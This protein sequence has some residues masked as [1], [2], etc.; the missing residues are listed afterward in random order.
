MRAKIKKG[1]MTFLAAAIL[2]GSF[3]SLAGMA[4][5]EPEVYRLDDAYQWQGDA[6]SM[7]VV[8]NTM[9]LTTG[10]SN[11]SYAIYTGKELEDTLVQFEGRFSI[12]SQWIAVRFRANEPSQNTWDNSQIYALLI[13]ENGVSVYRKQ[14]GVETTLTSKACSLDDGEFH[15]VKAGVYNSGNTAK[16]YFEVDGNILI[17]FADPSPN[18]LQSGFLSFNLYGQGNSL[19]VKTYGDVSETMQTTRKPTD[20]TWSGLINQE[21]W[22]SNQ[23]T[24]LV[25]DQ[26][27]YA[28]LNNKNGVVTLTGEGTATYR[29]K[30]R[31]TAFSFK[32]SVD[33]RDGVSEGFSDILFLKGTRASFYGKNSYSLRLTP[34]GR[35]SLIRYTND[36]AQTFP[37]VETGLDFTQPHEFMV[38]IIKTGDLS[39]EIYVYVD[40]GQ[41]GSYV[42]RDSKYSPNL[43]DYGF[44]GIHN[45]SNGVISTL[46]DVKIQGYEIRYNAGEAVAPLLYPDYLVEE[47]GDKII[48]WEYREDYVEYKGVQ[49]TD[50]NGKEIAYLAYPNNMYVLPSDH[51]Y[52]KLFVIPVGIDSKGERQLI[53]LQESREKYYKTTNPRIEVKSDK[54]GAYFVYEG[55]DQKWVMNGANYIGLRYGDHA[56]F[57]PAEGYTDAYY[58]EL[59][60]DSM[61]LNLARHGYNCVRVFVMGGRVAG[62]AGMAGNYDTT[63]GLYI[64]YMENVL[65]FLRRANKYG[66]YVI[67]NF[68]ENE[69]INSAYWASESGATSGQQILFSETGLAAKAKYMQLFLKYI[70]ERDP[71]VM[72]I[73]MAL[74]MQ[75]EFVFRAT[76][77]PF[78][79][80]SGSYTFLDGSTY[81]M[82]KTEERRALA[83]TAMK[84]YYQYMRDAVQE[85]VPD[86]LI[87]EGTFTNK[88]VKLDVNDEEVWGL[89]GGAGTRFPMTVP[90]LL[91]TAIDF[92]DIHVYRYGASGDADKVWKDNMDSMH[93]YTDKTAELLKSKPIVLGEYGASRGDEQESTIEAGMEFI[94]KLQNKA[95]EDG[96]Q[97]ALL[98]TLDSYSQQTWWKMTE[99]SGKWMDYLSVFA[100]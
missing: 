53:D 66:I 75:N 10:D 100:K 68:A 13:R 6:S 24:T 35:L 61:L 71:S 49:I 34:S 4:Q 95:L 72:N 93:F 54:D 44:F 51:T 94:K 81:D 69:M 40:G 91:D 60:V 27:K 59:T 43:Q 22:Y 12:E 18:S 82:S 14:D 56:T 30:L 97:G 7:S 42:Y 9:T 19:E 21:N 20:G 96:Y 84:N 57:E 74:S 80:T 62:N 47:K 64:P 3:G 92:L 89:R 45:S 83:V 99:E 90:E 52:T 28:Y 85:V 11:S 77:A 33:Y 31:T 98:W 39:S 17:D 8:G 41:N 15:T 58:D 36:V 2:F 5:S 86:M 79:Q 55:T 88:G 63:T 46:S 65:D 29:E 32:A 26:G 1:L 37:A 25:T 73:L 23:V 67:V 48:H 78:N 87:C 70:L 16:I 50:V 76:S 38:E